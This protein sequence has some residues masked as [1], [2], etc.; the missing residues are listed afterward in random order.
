MK[1]KTATEQMGFEKIKVPED[2]YNVVL[3]EVKDVSE[4]KYGPRVAFVCKLKDYVPETEL[5]LICQKS[6]VATPNNKLGQTLE[7]FG[8][9]LSSGEIDTE[10]IVGKE[11]R[12]LVENY[13]DSE[14]KEGSTITKVKKLE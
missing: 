8:I 3:T 6:E 4:G 12:A 7:V 9:D 1:I 2:W 10:A 14:G 13:K 5:A 11:A